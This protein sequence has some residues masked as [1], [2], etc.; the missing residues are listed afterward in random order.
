MTAPPS[1]TT[2]PF[3]K[4]LPGAV[5]HA[6]TLAMGA[7]TINVD[8]N[9]SE[10]STFTFSATFHDANGTEYSATAHEVTV[11]IAGETASPVPEEEGGSSNWLLWVM[12]GFGVLFIVAMVS[13]VVVLVQS[14]RRREQEREAE[15]LD[16]ILAARQEQHKQDTARLQQLSDPR[17]RRR[18]RRAARRSGRRRPAP[19]NR[20]GRDHRGASQSPQFPPGSRGQTPRSPGK[21][22]PPRRRSPRREAQKESRARLPL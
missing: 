22:R 14:S 4:L 16:R 18:G 21:R 11:T 9:V 15:E 17:A 1:C 19:R 6:N 8:L 7:Q 3:R 12:I 20:A 13:F 5:Y 2:S 10:T